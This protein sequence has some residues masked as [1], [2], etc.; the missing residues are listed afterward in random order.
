MLLTSGDY[1]VVP[2][3]QK[4]YS[5]PF[6]E[7]RSLVSVKSGVTIEWSRNLKKET[8]VALGSSFTGQVFVGAY[9]VDPKTLDTLSS[10]FSLAES[11]ADAEAINKVCW[12][13]L[14]N[15]G[16]PFIGLERQE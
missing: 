4:K 16:F 14:K 7:K 8:E 15:K 9:L 5:S 2:Y 12:D 6:F 13:L 3:E 11:D 10:V 1:F